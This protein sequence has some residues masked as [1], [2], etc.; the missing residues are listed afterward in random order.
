VITPRRPRN[1]QNPL[2]VVVSG[3]KYSAGC[4]SLWGFKMVLLDA[5]L[6]S[7]QLVAQLAFDVE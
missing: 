3:N 4:A 6:E 5:L 2:Q 1:P 7:G